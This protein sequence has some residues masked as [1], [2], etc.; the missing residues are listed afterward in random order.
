M[1]NV[2]CWIV[3][4]CFCTGSA[5][6]QK[7][8][9]LGIKA[10]LS[11]PNLSSGTSDNPIS[12]GYGSRLGPDVAVHAEFHL[13]KHFS[14]QPE[15]EYSSQGGKKN[16]NQAFTPPADL[17]AGIPPD[18][19]P[20]YLYADY[21][22]EAKFNYLMLPILAKYRLPLSRRWDFYVAA[23]PFVSTVLSAK[24]VTSGTSVV[25]ADPGHTQPV[26]P[27]PVPFDST[28]NIKADL[29]SFNA[30]ISGH[31]G[32]AVHIGARSSIFIEGGGNYGFVNIQKGTVNGKNNTGAAV[33][34]LGYSF[35]IDR[36]NKV[37]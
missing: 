11:I 30:G 24:N 14:V 4:V 2:I 29:H 27:G 17:V 23:G 20:P 37:N 12:S 22:S 18:Q 31:I 5:F 8:I 7:S 1:K 34:V 21:K 33:A 28:Q 3:F 36:F 25:Y 19:V 10:G 26:T 15:L 13:S 32:F 35:R 6:A 16:G 9:E